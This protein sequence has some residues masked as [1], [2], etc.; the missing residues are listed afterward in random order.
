MVSNKTL[1]Q[2][3]EL[4]SAVSHN[5][6]TEYSLSG[7][8]AWDSRPA[9]STPKIS[10]IVPTFNESEN[11]E[12][13][14]SELSKVLN[15]VE[16]E[17][18]FVD[19]DSPDGTAE[20]VR[21]I[22]RKYNRVRCVHRIGRR[23]L[24]A[25]CIEGMLASSA[26]Y[27]ALMDG[28]LQHDPTVIRRMFDILEAGEAEIVIG[29]RYVRGGGCG[30]YSKSRHRLSRLAALLSRIVLP[31]DL[32]DPMS[33][34]FA[35]RQELFHEVVHN[36]SRLSFKILFDIL[37][38][39]RRR[40]QLLEVPYV[41]RARRV[42]ESK[43]EPQ[44]AWEYL[45]LL[46]DKLIGRYIPVRVIAFATIGSLGVG[47]QLVALG[48]IYRGI[49]VRFVVADILATGISTVF[50]YSLHN[51][52]TYRSRRRHG[53]K[54]LSGLVVFAAVCSLGAAANVGLATYLFNQ[55]WHWL[56][57]ASAGVLAGAIW[58]YSATSF[59]TWGRY[60]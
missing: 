25:A 20:L 11:I 8:A 4:P 29:S 60:G 42:G 48:A 30:T 15:D 38:S 56:L 32:T 44:V 12:A 53:L 31:A 55:H 7:P 24:S 14:V 3:A 49:G 37:S 36:L 19:D 5:P 54:W 18:I 17:V 28:D 13:V 1:L 2:N 16:W 57:A 47:V 58:N 39:A 9:H 40:V 35:L 26:P 6:G 43:F 34:F 21:E 10:V 23:G 45:M 33:N 50:V 41:L 27:L 59:Y 22:G 46:C 51:F 52:L